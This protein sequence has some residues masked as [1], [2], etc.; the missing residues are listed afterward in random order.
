MQAAIWGNSII[1]YWVDRYRKQRLQEDAASATS[2]SVLGF[3]LRI[4]LWT[5]IVL[6][7]LDNLGIDITALIAG[8][9]VGGIAVALAVQNIL[10][11]L[12]ASLSIVMDN[13]L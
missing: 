6:L 10:G 3:V 9:G 12:F 8:L 4:A 1:Q 13:R 7:A 5:V 2:F 11:D